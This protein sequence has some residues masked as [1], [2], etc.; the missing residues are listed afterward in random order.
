MSV[1][2]TGVLAALFLFWRSYKRSKRFVRASDF[3]RMLDAGATPEEANELA[4]M[5][6]SKNSNPNLDN[7]AI[8][9][10]MAYSEA[11]FNGKQLP[12]IELAKQKGFTG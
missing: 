6:L 9:I 8:N 4:N 3:I 11:Q 1:I 10:A 12:V 7:R 2:I 5:L